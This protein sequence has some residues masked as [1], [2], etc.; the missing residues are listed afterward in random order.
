YFVHQSLKGQKPNFKIP[1]DDR[2]DGHYLILRDFRLLE[3]QFE[4]DAH[5]MFTFVNLLLFNLRLLL[6]R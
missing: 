1:L 3:V 4:K 2:N 5:S 6:S